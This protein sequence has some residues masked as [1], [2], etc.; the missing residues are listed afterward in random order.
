MACSAIVNP[1]GLEA[2][3]GRYPDS[4]NE[5]VPQMQLFLALSNIG[6]AL[7]ALLLI[8]PGHD[9]SSVKEAS[10]SLEKTLQKANAS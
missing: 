2:I 3:D 6:M 9:E 4:V 7:L 10:H 1:D 8:S 5:R